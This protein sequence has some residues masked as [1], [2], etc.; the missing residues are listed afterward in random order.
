MLQFTTDIALDA[1]SLAAF[2]AS[3]DSKQILTKFTEMYDAVRYKKNQVA[4]DT[5]MDVLIDIIKDLNKSDVLNKKT[6]YNKIILKIKSSPLAKKDSII[7]DNVA[8]MLQQGMTEGLGSKRELE[9]R[10]RIQNWCLI[11]ATDDQLIAGMALCRR[12]NKND[13]NANDLILANML[14]KAHEL[15]RI[16]STI[17]GATESIDELDFSSKSSMLD[18]ANKYAKRKKKNVIKLGWQG[19]NR[20]MGE[21]GGVCRGELVGFAA[22][23][24]NGKSLVLMKIARWATVYNKYELNDPSKIPTILL[25]SLE[26]EVSDDYNSMS[27]EAYVNAYHRPVP[28]DMSRDELIDINYKYYNECGN[29][30][31][32]KRFGED[33]GYAD[34]VKLIARLEMRNMEIVCLI[35]D[36]PALMKQETNDKDNAPKTLERLY[37]KLLDLSH[38]KDI[39]LFAGLQLDRTADKLVSQGEV[40]AVKKLTADALADSKGIKRALDILIFQMIEN[41]DGISYLTFSWN[42][43]RDNRPP[44][45]DD[46]FCGYRFSEDVGILDDLN[47]KDN[48]IHDIYADAAKVGRPKEADPEVA[49]KKDDDDF[50]ANIKQG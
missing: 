3:E 31:I 28:P 17:I 22:P 47:G 14:D 49:V 34:L 12:Y 20:M 36:Y 42:K 32:V 43:H 27:M 39:A 19:L 24:Y 18:S 30:L 23:S 40:C 6:E 7:T 29:R 1:L 37:Q 38:S 41:I 21:N 16:Q 15:T 48:S 2:S 45:T 10:R 44:R 9:L 50:F 25:V 8:A 11:S 5:D 26:N 35:I 33:F 13:D 46:K 4:I